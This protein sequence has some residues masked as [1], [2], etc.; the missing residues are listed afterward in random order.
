M[1][2]TE[3]PTM[4]SEP[5]QEG[6]KRIIPIISK[7]QKE[8]FNKFIYLIGKMEANGIVYDFVTVWRPGGASARVGPH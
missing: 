2:T 1:K 7:A 3:T 5:P 4:I 8:I 6:I